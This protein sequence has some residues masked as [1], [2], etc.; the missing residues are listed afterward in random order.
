MDIKYLIV[1]E[2]SMLE[3]NMTAWI[4]KQLRQATTHLDKPSGGTS[5]M[6]IGDFAQLPPVGDRP[7]F[8]PEGKGSHGQLS[9][10]DW[11][12]PMYTNNGKQ[13]K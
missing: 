8:A 4:D 10:A 5:V 11:T 1:D 7:L 9:E 6:F 13:F 2:V 3:Q 12:T